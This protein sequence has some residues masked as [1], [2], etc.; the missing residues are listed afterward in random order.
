[1]NPSSTSGLVLSPEK[2]SL[3]DQLLKARGIVRPDPGPIHRRETGD[4]AP[5]SLAQQRLSF[6]H[7][8]DPTSPFYNVAGAMQLG[9]RLDVAALSRALDALVERHEAMRTVFVDA[10]P[11]MRQRILPPFALA[12]PIDDLS[13]W[14]P[15]RRDAEARARVDAWARQ[16]FDLTRGPLVRARLLRLDDEMHLLAL[17]LHHIVCDGWSIAQ[18]VSD[19]AAAYAGVPLPPLAVQYADFAVWQRRSLQGPHVERLIEFWR[20]RLLPLPPSIELPADRPRRAAQSFRGRTLTRVVPDALLAR[21]RT[22]GAGRR[23]TLFHVLLAAFAALVARYTGE[24]DLCIGTLVANRSRPELEP[25]VG[26]FVNTLALRIDASGDPTAADLID[27]VRDASLSA[28]AYQELPFERLVEELQPHRSLAAQPLFNVMFIH[29]GASADGRVR[30]GDLDA[31]RV[32]VE[33][34]AS[35]FDLTFSVE[36]LDGQTVVQA[37]YSTELFDDDRIERMLDHWF[38]LINGA[39]ADVELRLSALPLLRPAERRTVLDTFNATD[40]RWTDDRVRLHEL[41]ERQAHATPDAVAVSF[42]GATLTYRALDAQANR[43]ARRLQAWGAGPET[44]VAVLAERCLGLVPAL[45]G[46]LKAGA[47]Y[48]PIDPRTPDDRL[49]WMLADARPVAVLSPRSH[50]ERFNAISIPLLAFDDPRIAAEPSQRLDDGPGPPGTLAYAI[51]TSGS[52][53][54][55]KCAA[56]THDAVVNRLRW[57]QQQFELGP[58]EAVLQK[59]TC[60]FDVSVWEIFWPLTAGARVVLARPDG[61]RDPRYLAETI[62][63]EQITTIHFVPPMLRVFLEEERSGACR[64]LRRIVCSGEALPPDLARACQTRLRAA[65]LHNLYGPTEAAIDVTHWPCR[66]DRDGDGVPIG[67]PIAN[68]RIYILDRHLQP[69]PIGVPGELYIGGRQVG[70]GYLARPALTAERF[71]PD[72]FGPAPGARL[73]RTGDIA[74]YRVDGAIEFLERA[75][76]QLKVRGFRIEPGEIEAAIGRVPGVA[77]AAVLARDDIPGDR[78]L[79]AYVVPA[80]TD[81]GPVEAP[82]PALRGASP[83]RTRDEALAGAIRETLPRALPE[84]MVPSAIVF[85]DRLPLTPNGKLDRRALPAPQGSGAARDTGSGSRS[86]IG[87][88]DADAPSN[89]IEAAIAHM[90]RG[91]LGVEHLGVRDN[92]FELGGHSLLAAQVLS[93]VRAAF[94]V[95]VEMRRLFEQP[96]VA[97]LSRAVV[98]AGEPGSAHTMW[99]AVE[100][101]PR[102]ADLP[103]SFSQQ[104]LWFLNQLEPESPFYNVAGAVRLRGALDVPALSHALDATI[105]RHE[106]L[107]TVF[108]EGAEGP[109]QRVQAPFTLDLP[110]DDLSM[111]DPDRREAE[112]RARL[113]TLARRPFDLARGPLVRA[114]LIRLADDEHLLAL[115]LHHIICD[116]W[117]LTPLVS[118]L[119]AAYGGTPLPPLSVHY[120]DFTI[121]Q[122]RHLEGTRLERLLAFWRDRLLPSPPPLELPADRARSGA[123]AFRGRTIRRVLGSNARDPAGGGLLEAVRRLGLE[124]GATTFQ[125]LLTAF[126]ALLARYTGETDLCI[127]MPVANRQRPE[128]EPLV[129]CFV[130]TLALRIDAGGSPSFAELL[131]RVRNRSLAAFAHDD[132]PFERLV[133]E[134]QPH[135][136]LSTQPLFNVLFVYQN[137]PTLVFEAPGLAIERVEIDTGSAILDLTL[138]I[139]ERDGSLHAAVEYSTERFDDER[140]ARLLDHYER[141]LRGGL[142]Q[143]AQRI[144]RITILDATERARIDAWS[145]TPAPVAPAALVHAAFETWAASTPARIAIAAGSSQLTYGELNARADQL[146]G[147][148]RARGAGPERPVALC[149]D[150]SADMAIAVLATL[151]AGAAYVPIDPSTPGTRIAFMLADARPAAVLIHE[152]WRALAPEAF[153]G[154]VSFECLDRSDDPSGVDV[155]SHGANPD[156]LVYLIY[157]SGSTGVPKAVAM[158]HR[159]LSRLIAWHLAALPR[160]LDTLAFASLAFDVSA[161]ELLA[162]LSSG[163]RL[164]V[165]D[166]D[167]RH[168]VAALARRIDAAGVEL[169]ILPVVV[170]QQLASYAAENPS[171]L[172]SLKRLVSTGDP[173]H[174]HGPVRA[175][176]RQRPGLRLANY[177]GPSETHVA[178]A[179]LLA[180][181]PAVWPA[182]PAI[183]HAISGSVARVL[184][185]ALDRAPVGVPGELY[186][187]GECLAR[188]YLDR[189]ALTAECFLPDPFGPPGARLY[190]TG[191]LAR[192]RRD[193]TLEYLGRRDL[194]VKV[195]GHRVE[196]GEVEAAIANLEGVRETAV[197]P[198][199]SPTGETTLAAFV[200]AETGCDLGQVRRSLAQRLP[201]VMVPA[202]WIPL[203][204]LPLNANGKIDRPKLVVPSDAAGA[205]GRFV[206]PR[207]AAEEAVAAIWRDVLQ[208]EQV[209]IRDDFF[210]LGGH[211]LM[212]AR[213]AARVRAVFGIDLPVRAMFETPTIETLTP[214]VMRASHAMAPATTDPIRRRSPDGPVP[215]A[216]AQERLWFLDRLAPGSAAYAMPAAI[217]LRGP[218]DVARLQRALEA[219]VHRHEVLR[220]TF[221]LVDGRPVQV[222]APEGPLDVPLVDFSAMRE[223]EAERAVRRLA[224]EQER[225]P[226]ALAAGPLVRARLV[227]LADAHHI[228]LFAT[229][230][231]V[232]DGWSL[233]VL[234]REIGELYAALVEDRPSPLA[235]LP[236]QYADFAV[237]QRAWVERPEHACQLEYWTEQLAG[238]LPLLDLPAD[239][240]RPSVLTFRGGMRTTVLDRDLSEALGAFSRRAQVTLFMTLLAAFATLLFRYTG[241]TDVA[242]GSGVANRGRRELEPLIGCFI[243]VLVLR[244][245]VSG[246]PSFRELLRRVRDVTLNAYAN[247]DVPFERIVDALQPDRDIARQPLFQVMLV[248]HNEPESELRLG[249]LAVSPVEIPRSSAQFDLTLHVRERRDGLTLALEYGADL[250]D[251]STADRMLEH[252]GVL[253]AAAIEEPERAVADLPILRPTERQLVAR[254]WNA[255]RAPYPDRAC[256]HEIVEAHVDRDPAAAAILNGGAPV[257]FG[258][259]EARANQLAHAL[260]QCGVVPDTCVGVGLERSP[261]LIVATLAVLKA[262]GAFVPLDARYPAERLTHMVRDAGVSTVIAKGVIAESPALHGVRILGIDSPAV[263]LESTERPAPVATPEH[264]A[265]VI[266]TSGSTGTPKGV[267]VRH[268]GALNNVADL[269]RRFE[270]GAADSVLSLSSPSFDMS[271]YEHLG[272]LAAGGRV[273]VPEPGGERDPACWAALIAEHQ[274]TVWNSAPAL[275]EMLVGFAAG[276]PDVDLHSLRVALL[277]GDRIAVTLPDRLRSLA[278]RVRVIGLGGATEASIHSTV[279]PVDAVDPAWTRIPYGRPMANQTTYVLDSRLQPVPIGVR[280]ELFLGGLGL[281][282]GYLRRPDLTAERFLPNPLSDEP[283]ARMYRTGD[284]ARFLPDGTLDLLGR[285]DDQVK[286]RGHRV[287]PGE[288]AAVLRE[289]PEVADAA[290]AAH[291]DRSGDVRLCAY[292]RWTSDASPG[293]DRLMTYLA[294][295]LP[296]YMTPAA[297]VTLDRLPLSPNGKLDRRALPRPDFDRLASDA[298]FVAPRTPTEERL[299]ELWRDLLGLERVGTRDNFFAQGGHSLLAVRLA[300]GVRDRFGV[301]LSLRAI[302]ENPTPAAVAVRIDEARTTQA[303]PTTPIPRARREQFRADGR[304]R[305]R[306]R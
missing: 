178:T 65:A 277:G 41:V 286:I 49:S 66:V 147:R 8:L 189:P 95:D 244:M 166:E 19:L 185:D 160:P 131:A 268:G 174:V 282:R 239:R 50:V 297:I 236:F 269:N 72:P 71:V 6:L 46:V 78:R 15:D 228:L 181:E 200:V 169:A 267:A 83:R 161:L 165:A 34:G 290:A 215:L 125:V 176:F 30:L 136:S 219:V 137:T 179:H 154:A 270:I 80:G 182:N 285:V 164:I 32:H 168:D 5:L 247:Q 37:E 265:Y 283:G 150:R 171:A 266:Y 108:V 129:G 280:G 35:R 242:I 82:P 33:T 212:A 60:S 188:A 51:Y 106:S 209:G 177:Y 163:R 231:I 159:P 118:D 257:T 226:F 9:G 203:D 126:A 249:S 22:M 3:L 273:I 16:P 53:G 103:L 52:T 144:P 91:L 172:T 201:D 298:P 155:A 141:L 232:A 152:R 127:G 222:V 256:L 47:A 303:S 211:S 24:T 26:F 63:R 198:H 139:E 90:W 276:R 216:F 196:V 301:D 17:A 173:L 27:R 21:A 206:P 278:P 93:R 101:A 224:A 230:H 74:R 1:M 133:E 146:A 67:R 124:R 175:M 275:L 213:V 291:R 102:G 4:E 20:E 59:T 11:E 221:P 248:V 77:H 214:I 194:Q 272:L 79:V 186:L 92:F 202:I 48:L 238:R 271:V 57:M 69:A 252:L 64:S 294:H 18:L 264:L 279:F 253:L 135:R 94:G 296:P 205:G 84:Y 261:D 289:H 58:G 62:T 255:T 259:L 304:A 42:E 250:F 96:T 254:A 281:A 70:R 295:R 207:T 29:Q 104:R 81:A 68:T 260:R 134:L 130:N 128:L 140:I 138:S 54:R 199:R 240:P 148:L 13:A 119:T 195:H 191:D 292:V 28:F 105:A 262:G 23:A 156:H 121:W 2:R 223:P 109:S 116:G 149:L 217:R 299:A 88:T 245:D 132:L 184:D 123:Q 113:D 115:A 73:Y 210:V 14:P 75:D 157:T 7:R 287:E 167:A 85:V 233:A 40:V 55:P 38:T 120:V 237:W 110:V 43:I 302:F 229:H 89:H 180:P 153:A 204:Q 241:Q 258:D 45:L 225:E 218:L 183:G 234:T 111:L 193:G 100:P 76:D 12:L 39:A 190:R 10:E 243:N 170:L 56:N 99:P 87:S 117:S 122:R 274:V 158:P 44:L 143:P 208:I 61:H 263:R 227:R 293:V 162:A 86:G 284:L 25:L 288:I 98:A 114:H 145:K 97:A 107:R 235:P 31:R 220:T 192:A 36:A 151:K 251:A 142:D 187:G 305:T 197:M 112:T 300:A 306:P 246:Q